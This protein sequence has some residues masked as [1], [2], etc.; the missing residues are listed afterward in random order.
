MHDFNKETEITPED[1]IYRPT[2]FRNNYS[3]EKMVYTMSMFEKTN[4]SSQYRKQEV[5]K[6]EIGSIENFTLAIF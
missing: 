4:F 5:G 1:L 6:Q 3:A 2:F